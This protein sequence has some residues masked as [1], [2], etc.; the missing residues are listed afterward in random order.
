MA[1]QSQLI[2]DQIT[3]N[4]NPLIV[5]A[6]TPP[7]GDSSNKIATTAFV[8]SSITGQWGTNGNAIYNLNTSGN[9]GIGTNTPLNN[10]GSGGLEVATTLQVDGSLT[11]PN[12]PLALAYGGTGLNTVGAADTL[13]GVVDAGGSLEYKT[14]TSTSGT[15]GYTYSAGSVSIDV[16]KNTTPSPVEVQ[17][18]GDNIGQEGIVNFESSGSL[19]LAGSNNTIAGV[20][21]VVVNPI[22]TFRRAFLLKGG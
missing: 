11:L 18:N 21:T 7:L 20:I 10:S 16:I 9:V 5:T 2:V 1:N 6:P 19:T 13:L 12:T 4:T 22:P 14:L 15:I 3:G 17:V 8:A